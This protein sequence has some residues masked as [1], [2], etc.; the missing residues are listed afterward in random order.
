MPDK[1]KLERIDGAQNFMWCYGYETHATE[2]GVI[3]VPV[4]SAAVVV[5]T[6]LES[7]YRVVE[8]KTPQ[9]KKATS[10][11]EDNN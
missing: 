8:P 7:I 1:V 2:N 9:K 5:G 10:K 6:A 11:S 4:K 3:V